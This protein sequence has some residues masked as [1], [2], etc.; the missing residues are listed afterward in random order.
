MLRL[1]LG[2]KPTSKSQM[3]CWSAE[4]GDR[5][6][7]DFRDNSGRAGF[8]ALR[9]PPWGPA[10]PLAWNAIPEKPRAHR[11]PVSRPMVRPAAGVR[12]TERRAVN[13]VSGAAFV[14]GSL[15]EGARTSKEHRGNMKTAPPLRRRTQGAGVEHGD[16]ACVSPSSP[17]TS[18]Q[19]IL[20]IW[21]PWGSGAECPRGG[22]V[23]RHP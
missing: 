21:R 7:G 14:P 13:G 11:A 6:S 22:S 23:D 8:G 17:S 3:M 15:A 4:V 19:G 5:V 10:N 2:E 12:D 20:S 16:T 9:R 18:F 1:G